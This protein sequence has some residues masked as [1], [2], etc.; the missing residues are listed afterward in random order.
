MRASFAVKTAAASNRKWLRDTSETAIDGI[1]SRRSLH[2]RRDGTRIGDVV[3]QVRA[4]VDPRHEEIDLLLPEDTVRGEVHAIGRG[5]VDGV[6]PVAYLFDPERLRQ[7]KRMSRRT[8]F[9][10]RR[11]HDLTH[12]QVV[13]DALALLGGASRPVGV[14]PYQQPGGEATLAGYAFPTSL[15]WAVVLERSE[16]DA[17]MAVTRMRQSLYYAVLIG[18]AIAILGALGV[19]VKISRPVEQMAEV[20][21][22]VG[23]GDLDVEVRELRQRD[24]IGTSN[25]MSRSKKN[26]TISPPNA[27]CARR[28]PAGQCSW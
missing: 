20:A 23:E 8:S 12:R 15:S 4:L 6:Y 25:T 13:A 1:P 5:S 28:A 17:Y 11:D 14:R 3:S 19:A 27:D 2:R 7:R 21:R 10:V 9:A 24:E 26:I 16:S 18:L 22:R